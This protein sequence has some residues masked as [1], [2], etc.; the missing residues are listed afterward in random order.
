MS[1]PVA[2]FQKFVA[3]HDRSLSLTVSEGLARFTCPGCSQPAV[4]LITGAVFWV[5]HLT[6]AGTVPMFETYQGSCELV[7]ID[8]G[9]HQIEPS[10][11]PKNPP[12]KA[13]SAPAIPAGA[14]SLDDEDD[15][16]DW[17]IG[18]LIARGD[19]VSLFGP[20]GVGK[21]LLSLDWALRMARQGSRVL[22]LDREN[23]VP[24]IRSRLKA[25]GAIAD[26]M[27][28]LAVMPFTEMPDLATPQGAEAL[29]ELTDE[30]GSTVLMLDTIS[31]FSQTGQ[32]GMSDRWQAMYNRSF[33][34]L[35][36]TGM[37][38]LQIDHTG[39]ANQ[40][41]E[42]DSSAK[43]DNVSLA[44][45]LMPAAGMG[46]GALILTRSK[47]R[48][49]HPGPDAV[50]LTRVISPVLTHVT[51][52]PLEAEVLS[53]L[54]ALMKLNVPVSAGRV[55]AGDILRAAGVSVSTDVLTQALRLRKASDDVEN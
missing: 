41:R 25:M 46:R 4:A 44:Y 30:H 7:R 55:V 12:V 26:D 40:E 50:T 47:N 36:S 49:A 15:V 31:K 6:R 22:Y 28:R 21:S 19:Y 16:R 53:M 52:K 29:D 54:G 35:L 17:L 45:G 48:P 34:P 20:S 18:D 33:V 13:R 32:A 1:T 10:N 39:H 37:T 11:L 42:R 23:P 2:L 9:T 24:V 3:E 38:I 8:D 14:L 51:G 5:T 27:L 43:R